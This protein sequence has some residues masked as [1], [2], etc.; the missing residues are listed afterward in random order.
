MHTPNTK[1]LLAALDDG[2][3]HAPHEML[4]YFLS[5]TLYGLCGLPEWQPTPPEVRD[6]IADAMNEYGNL[7]TSSPPFSDILGPIYTELR[8]KGSK[9]VLGQSFTPWPVASMMSRMTAG[10]RPEP[11]SDG[12]LIRICDPACGSGVM[13]L[14]F[15]NTV[16]TDWGID[17]LRRISVT[18]CDLDAYCSRMM[19]T[20]LL[21]NI[22]QHDL[23]LGEIVVLHGN[24]LTPWQN[25]D[26]ILHASSPEAVIIPAQAPS[27]LQALACAAASDPYQTQL[28]LFEAA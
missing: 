16:L 15:L 8:G 28:N 25:L 27:R 23:T 26:T 19:A 14:A 4:G 3:R 17:D 7:V 2:Y 21:A 5:Q 20:Q 13:M 22:T 24:S 11:A 9:Q 1:K 18:G 12:R 6:T 10:E